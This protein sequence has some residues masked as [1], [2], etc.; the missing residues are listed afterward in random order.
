[1]CTIEVERLEAC[2]DGRAVFRYRTEQVW[3]AE[4]IKKLVQFGSL[5]Y[6]PEF[7]RPYFRVRNQGG[8]EIKGLE[9]ECA[10]RVI[11]PCSGREEWRARWE[12]FLQ[13]SFTRPTH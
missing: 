12:E 8:L 6:F 11:F 3:T 9:G 5:D 7:P 10:C 1:M 13:H 4:T 2:L